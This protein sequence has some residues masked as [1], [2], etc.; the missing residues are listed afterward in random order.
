MRVSDSAKKRRSPEFLR[1]GTLIG[2]KAGKV[3][4]AVLA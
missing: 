2:R 4:K 3:V 1:R